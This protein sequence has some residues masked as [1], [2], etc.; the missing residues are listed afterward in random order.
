MVM[1]TR[2]MTV[3][4]ASTG[5]GAIPKGEYVLFSVRDT[6]HGMDDKT[7]AQVFEPFFTTKPQGK[8]TGLGLSTVYGIVSQNN[9]YIRVQSQPGEGTTFQIHFPRETRIDVAVKQAQ[10]EIT[11]GKETILLVEDQRQVRNLS[12]RILSRAGYQVL[13]AESG[14]AALELMEQTDKEIHLLVTDVVMPG[15]S[16][17]ELHGRL[18][19]LIPGLEVLYM[20]GYTEDTIAHHGVLEAGTNFL[21]KP[22]TAGELT[23][24]VRQVLD[25]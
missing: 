15:M 7:R 22:F 8:G 20:S 2:N 21:P 1:S 19:T 25:Q 12:H 11:G 5:L 9:G 16:G 24:K 17:K 10:E 23:N 3:R 14:P 4:D 13:C 18:L 6:G